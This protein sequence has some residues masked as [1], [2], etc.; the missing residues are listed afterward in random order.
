MNRGLPN[1]NLIN[2]LANAN[3][4]NVSLFLD[5]QRNYTELTSRI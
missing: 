4:T 3:S 2:L 5:P 1:L